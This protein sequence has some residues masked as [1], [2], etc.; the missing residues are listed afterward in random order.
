MMNE[1]SLPYLP[2]KARK[3]KR[4][5]KETRRKKKGGKSGDSLILRYA[6]N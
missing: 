5:G 3:K 6:Q 4:E 1:L 2:G